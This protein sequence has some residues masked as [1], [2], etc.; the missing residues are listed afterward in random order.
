MANHTPGISTQWGDLSS[1]TWNISPCIWCLKGWFPGPRRFWLMKVPSLRVADWFI[2]ICL[3]QILHC[4]LT[5]ETSHQ[6]NSPYYKRPDVSWVTW[7]FS[8]AD[9]PSVLPRSIWVGL[10]AWVWLEFPVCHSTHCANRKYPA[11][12]GG[13][14]CPEYTSRGLHLTDFWPRCCILLWHRES[15]QK[16]LVPTPTQTRRSWGGYLGRGS[17]S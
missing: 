17:L 14:L 13:A 16:V 1:W 10:L 15:L 9:T 3:K 12:W 11:A 5:A 4:L 8:M 6:K 7:M 2:P